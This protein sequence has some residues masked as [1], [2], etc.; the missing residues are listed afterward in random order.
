MGDTWA[1]DKKDISLF[2]ESLIINMLPN[3]KLNALGY[4]ESLQFRCL[5]L[6]VNS[7]CSFVN[8]VRDR[9]C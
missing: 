2:L 6:D 5:V 8:D 9:C 3:V 1:R 4:Y 7:I